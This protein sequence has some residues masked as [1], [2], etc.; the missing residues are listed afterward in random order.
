MALGPY[1]PYRLVV[2]LLKVGS[3]RAEDARLGRVGIAVVSER[4]RRAMKMQRSGWSL[5]AFGY[6]K[7][8]ADLCVDLI[9][10]FVLILGLHEWELV[11][12]AW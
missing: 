11:R 5:R 1:L 12:I 2:H 6:V 4:Y 7:R 10:K 9:E 3:G 8:L